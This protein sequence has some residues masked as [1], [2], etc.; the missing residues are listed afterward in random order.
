MASESF[1]DALARLMAQEVPME[2]ADGYAYELC[3]CCGVRTDGAGRTVLTADGGV[4]SLCRVC[5]EV[6]QPDP[7][8]ILSSEEFVMLLLTKHEHARSET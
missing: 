3:S 8:L 5:Y 1:G 2:Y 6:E 7:A 4:R